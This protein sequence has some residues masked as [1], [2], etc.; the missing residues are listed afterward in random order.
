M[1]LRSLGKKLHA[2]LDRAA[3]IVEKLNKEGWDIQLSLYDILLSPPALM[4]AAAV[5]QKLK[6]L[7]IDPRALSIDEQLGEEIAEPEEEPDM[8]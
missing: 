3:E 4:T 8:D 5:C 6:D 2:R 7:G 1:R